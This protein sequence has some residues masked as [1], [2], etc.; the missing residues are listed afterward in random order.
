MAGFI[1][2]MV[3]AVGLYWVSEG[4][5]TLSTGSLFAWWTALLLVAILMLWTA[6]LWARFITGFF[7]GP[8][9]LK[10]L[11]VLVLEQD[12]YYSSHS[13]SRIDLAELLAYSAAVVALTWRFVGKRPV[14]TTFFDRLAL[15][16]FVFATTKQVV[17]P[18]R[19]PPW[20]LLSGGIALLAAWC[21][22][23]FESKKQKREHHA[24]HHQAPA[25]PV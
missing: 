20:F 19:F 24:H 14:P 7:F 10:V 1:V 16:F 9:V 3:V 13:L 12:S 2:I 25:A 21:A 17:A 18:Y 8:A 5:S 23:Y 4:H 6:N 22:Y 15:T 11:A